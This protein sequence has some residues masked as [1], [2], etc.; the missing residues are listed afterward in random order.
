[1]RCAYARADVVD[2]RHDLGADAELAVAARARRRPSRRRSGAPRYA[3]LGNA[4]ARERLA[5]RRSLSALAPCEPPIT[6]TVR[7]RAAAPAGSWSAMRAASTN[8][9]RTGL[10]STRARSAPNCAAV[11]RIRQVRATDRRREQAVGQPD[12]RVLLEQRGR[13]AQRGRREQHRARRV[14]AQT[15]H[16]I[17]PERRAPP[18]APA[19]RERGKRCDVAREL[20]RPPAEPAARRR[21]RE[22]LAELPATARASMPRAVPT[23]STS[24]CGACAAAPRPPRSRE[25]DVRRCR[26]LPP[27]ALSIMRCLRRARLAT[28]SLPGAPLAAAF[29]S[30]HGFARARHVQ[31]NRRS[32]AQFT[33]SD[34][35]P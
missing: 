25:T 5:A 24:S 13:H 2:E 9:R 4:G 27:R 33:S 22:A 35:P 32:R 3:E 17:G 28:L 30:R 23:N 19:A 20:E 11:S 21:P 10:P 1:M 29:G 7:A 8:A 14:A 26:R 18:T 12:V 31:Q 34:E 15:E 16:Q 6:S